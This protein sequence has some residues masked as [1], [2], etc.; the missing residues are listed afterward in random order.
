MSFIG[1]NVYQLD[2]LPPY[3]LITEV[4][5]IGFPTQGILIKDTSNSSVRSLSTGVNVYAAIEADNH[6][7]YIAETFSVCYLFQDYYSFLLNFLNS[8]T[9]GL[10]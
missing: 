4:S 2:Q 1:L 5:P 6:L 8:M 3:N 9:L 10:E 7:Y